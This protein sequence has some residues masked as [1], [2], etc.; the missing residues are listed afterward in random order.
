[1]KNKNACISLL[2]NFLDCGYLDLYILD[3]TDED[4][5]MEAIENLKFNGL[6]P[7][8]N[9]ITDEMFNMVK[10]E[11]IAALEV[12][13][14]ELGSDEANGYAGEYELTELEKIKTLNPEEDIEW[15]CNCLDTS[16]YFICSDEK[17]AI[18]R[19]YFGDLIDE[20][21]SKMGFDIG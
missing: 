7:T 19:E 3:D 14:D 9:M 17:E 5:L 8:L 1:M 11:I 13:I 4:F 16:I 10:G 18:Y 2:C 12:R 15:F 6:S 20:L 21:E